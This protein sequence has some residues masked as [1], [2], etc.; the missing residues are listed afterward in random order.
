MYRPECG[1]DEI[2]P[3]PQQKSSRGLRGQL[4]E[5]H[6][7]LHCFPV[8]CCRFRRSNFIDWSPHFPSLACQLISP[9][10]DGRLHFPSAR[11][12]NQLGQIDARHARH[13]V[14][15]GYPDWIQV[16]RDFFFLTFLGRGNCEGTAMVSLIGW[17]QSR[18]HWATQ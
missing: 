18:I 11:D 9:H 7:F 3:A 8:H 15:T 5:P 16:I 17:R 12:P 10:Q 6:P 1:T 4:Q 2:D 13:R 14:P